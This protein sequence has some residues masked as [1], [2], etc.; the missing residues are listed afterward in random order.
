MVSFLNC[1][2]GVELLDIFKLSPEPLV[3]EVRSIF[4][5]NYFDVGG[6]PKASLHA[7]SP[8]PHHYTLFSGER[9][10]LDFLFY[11]Y[12]QVWC[13]LLFGYH[14]LFSLPLSN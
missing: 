2:Q 3:T 1:I 8:P 11:L 5:L 4:G 10:V 7:L 6:I 12:L 14:I 9:R 13:D